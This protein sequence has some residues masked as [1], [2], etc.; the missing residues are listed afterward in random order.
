ML[1]AIL[2]EAQGDLPDHLTI[3]KINVDEAKEIGAEYG[4]Q[5]LP[6]LLVLKNRVELASKTG[7]ISKSALIQWILEVADS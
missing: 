5:S 6:T 4:I 3:V 1:S 7:F 2:E